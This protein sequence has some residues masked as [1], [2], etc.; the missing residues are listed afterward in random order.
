VEAD[1]AASCGAAEQ[2]EGV[3]DPHA[4]PLGEQALRL[5]YDDAGVESTLQLLDAVRQSRDVVAEYVRD[6]VLRQDRKLQDAFRD[7][8]VQRLVADRVDVSSSFAHG[9]ELRDGL[10]NG[11]R[12]F[13]TETLTPR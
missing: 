9:I 8:V 4:E 7:E 10:V 12:A 6:H 1:A 3:V 5:L 11:M 13:C 2:L